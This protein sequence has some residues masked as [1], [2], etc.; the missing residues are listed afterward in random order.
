MEEKKTDGNSPAT[1][2]AEVLERGTFLHEPGLTKREYFAAVAM[3]GIVANSSQSP[4]RLGMEEA[5]VRMADALI[6]ALN[7]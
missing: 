6:L 7:K 2:F 5:A 3:A 4:Y 1:G